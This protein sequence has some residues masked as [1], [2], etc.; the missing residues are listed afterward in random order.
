MGNTYGETIRIHRIMKRQS[1]FIPVYFVN[2][3]CL[4]Q[5]SKH[6]MKLMSHLGIGTLDL[7]NGPY[8]WEL[9]LLAKSPTFMWNTDRSSPRAHQREET[10]KRGQA[11]RGT[12]SCQNR[13]DDFWGPRRSPALTFLLQSNVCCGK[14]IRPSL[15]RLPPEP[16]KP[17]PGPPGPSRY[18]LSAPCTS[19]NCSRARQ[20]N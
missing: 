9:A 3:A 20:N 5:A 13:M 14:P 8:G 16:P 2:F 11:G 10:N 4:T 1:R 19:T 12:Q 18:Y 17:L 6:A 7:R 15:R